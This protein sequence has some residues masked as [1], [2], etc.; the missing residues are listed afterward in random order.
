MFSRQAFA[1]ISLLGAS[2]LKC[3]AFGEH[4][5]LECDCIMD[6]C[7]GVAIRFLVL[8]SAI[9]NMPATWASETVLWNAW[10]DFS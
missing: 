8:G 5:P 4:Y 2:K 3:A 7:K 6:K 9:N 1:R 10:E